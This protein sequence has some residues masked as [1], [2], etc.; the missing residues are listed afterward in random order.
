[1]YVSSYSKN[2]SNISTY[3]S[4]IFVI[5]TNYKT[6][7]VCVR[8]N[9][10]SLKLFK[11]KF[12]SFKKILNR[13]VKSIYLFYLVPIAI[14]WKKL[15]DILLS[16]G[17][18]SFNDPHSYDLEQFV[19][20]LLLEIQQNGTFQTP[21]EARLIKLEPTF[22][23]TEKNLVEVLMDEITEIFDHLSYWKN[24]KSCY[25]YRVGPS[26]FPDRYINI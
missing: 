15:L 6:N 3:I 7:L 11:H 14:E 19:I 12:D 16:I 25:R 26:Y 5:I 8:E 18:L 4:N 20:K 17:K 23:S 1:M 24:L 21:Y 13:G 10:N 9:S 22:H 2:L